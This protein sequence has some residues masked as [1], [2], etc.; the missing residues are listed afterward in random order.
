MN[1]MY[2]WYNLFELRAIGMPITM[3]DTGLR[4]LI[5]APQAHHRRAGRTVPG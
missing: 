1:S 3:T 5:S 4:A 2:R